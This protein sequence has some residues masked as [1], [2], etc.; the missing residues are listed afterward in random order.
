MLKRSL[1]DQG[2]DDGELLPCVRHGEPDVQSF[3]IMGLQLIQT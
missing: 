3:P 2:I 1:K